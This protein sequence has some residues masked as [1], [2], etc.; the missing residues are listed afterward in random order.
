M[1]IIKG[2]LVKRMAVDATQ[3][4]AAPFQPASDTQ[5]GPIPYRVRRDLHTHH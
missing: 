5:H 4:A 2:G 1:R 3:Q